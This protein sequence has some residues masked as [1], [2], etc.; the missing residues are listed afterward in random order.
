MEDW[1][2]IKMLFIDSLSSIYGEREA[3]NLF[4]LYKDFCKR[5]PEKKLPSNTVVSKLIKE[6]PLQYILGEA[7]FY[8][9]DFYVDKNVLIPRP[10]TEELVYTVLQNF[11]NSTS[12]NVLD[13][14]TGSG[15][16]PISLK[17][18]RPD[19]SLT[20]MDVSETA[21]EVS[22][23]NGRTIG[24]EVDWVL[25]D[26]LVADVSPRE[27]YD[28]IVSNPPYIPEKDKQIMSNNVLEYEP[29]LA[30]FVDNSNPLIFYKKIVTLALKGWLKPSGKI[31]FEIHQDFGKKM[32]SY[33]KET[34]N[35]T[36]EIIKDLQGNDRIMI[37]SM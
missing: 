11:K 8:G 3:L 14:G 32:E 22:Q 13:I 15:C 1:E 31:F 19:W 24:A 10:E 30:L 33:F 4:K 6:E 28:I 18:N 23:R 16:I 37:L 29:S 26:V 20:G 7:H 2:G 17:K 12:L 35:M 34:T 25:K 27:P 21:L 36:S 9:F 5:N